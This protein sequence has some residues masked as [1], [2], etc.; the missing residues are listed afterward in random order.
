MI[1]TRNGPET[2]KQIDEELADTLIAI[3]VVAKNLAKRIRNNNS[4]EEIDD[5]KNRNR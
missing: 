4:G 5:D 3:S 2:M 1:E